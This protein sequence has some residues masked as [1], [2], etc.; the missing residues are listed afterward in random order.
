MAVGCDDLKVEE[1]IG[2]LLAD[3][4]ITLGLAE[5]CTGGL[6]ASRITSVPGSSA[7]FT[8]C[9]VAYDNRVKEKLLAVPGGELARYG[10]V[11]GE[12]ARSMAG[13]AKRVLMTDISLA[14]TGIAGPGGG[15]PEK[16]A[17][18][19]YVALDAPGAVVTK[20]LHLRGDRDQIRSAIAQTALEMLL[21][22]LSS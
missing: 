13:G 6:I 21:Q 22:Y 3:R 11:S 2:R 18:L 10:A 17:G 4:G 5:S 19:V 14:V 16:P 8:G 20:E 1:E 7:Y 9:V 15:T 12:V